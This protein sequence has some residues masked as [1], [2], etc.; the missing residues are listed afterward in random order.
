MNRQPHNSLRTRIEGR[1]C[2]YCGERPSTDE[3]FPPVSHGL[4]GFIFPACSECNALAGTAFARDFL[5]RA[6]LVKRRLSER[7]SEVT[8][9]AVLARDESQWLVM[10]HEEATR[11]R[12][13]DWSAQVYLHSIAEEHFIAIINSAPEPEPL[14]EPLNRIIRRGPRRPHK[15][16]VV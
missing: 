7:Y 11:R 15:K 12:R 4:G 3:H 1:Y 10:L 13:L 16:I 9:D 5:R 8:L 6:V 14:A 2:V